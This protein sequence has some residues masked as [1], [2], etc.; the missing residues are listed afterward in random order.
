MRLLVTGGSG[1]LGRWV[2]EELRGD[3]EVV[4]AGLE[5]TPPPDAVR[6]GVRYEQADLTDVEAV[7]R[8]A[9]GAE[10]IVHLAAIPSPIG[11]EPED[12]FANNMTSTFNVVE[13]AIRQDAQKVIYSSSGSAPRLR[14][15]LPRDGPGLHAHGRGAPAAPQD[16]YGLS[17][18][19]GEE[20]L[21][22]A[23]RRTG[24]RTIVL[25]P[26]SVIGPEDYAERVPRMLDNGGGIL[27]YVDA[28]DF[29][30]A[31]RAA[32]DDT[33][34]EHDRFF[35]TA[36]DAMSREPLA[37]AFPRRF[38]GSEAACAASRGPR[39][40]SAARRRSACSA[41]ARGT[42]GAPSWRRRARD[43]HAYAR[44]P[45]RRHRHHRGPRGRAP[46]R[47]GE[48]IDRGTSCLRGAASDALRDAP[49]RRSGARRRRGDRRPPTLET[50][51]RLPTRW[52]AGMLFPYPGRVSGDAFEFRG[53]RIDLPEDPQAGNAMHGAVRWRAWRRHRLRRGPRA[54]R[55][56]DNAPR[57]PR[58]RHPRQRVAVGLRLHAAH[59]AARRPAAHRGAHRERERRA[60]AVRPRLPPLP[61]DPARPAGS[62]EDCEV[63]LAATERWISTSTPPAEVS[64]V[65]TDEW[66]RRALPLSALPPNANTAA[67]PA[68]NH[69][70]ILRGQSG[71][72]AGEEPG[73]LRGRLTDRA[74]GLE[75]TLDASEGMRTVVF[76]TPPD[77][78][79]V[80]FEPHTC[81]PN[82]F[83]LM[84]EGIPD[85]GLIVLEPGEAW[86]GWYE[87]RLDA[88]P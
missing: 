28:R 51:S 58:G 2:V 42:A 85:P 37:T 40:R 56:G 77:A 10:A 19:L 23:T 76:Y 31:V 5:D 46:A 30:R 59:R 45:L 55:L 68:R 35:I 82:A 81:M 79:V 34:I 66:P 20:I 11:R 3:H 75:A 25:R 73:P 86:D 84:T 44:R 53:R 13:A 6:P 9:E 48:R 33:E 54:G 62:A 65:A 71:D 83:N 74:N 41:T 87:L 15:P 24:I 4:V 18:W 69:K 78:P 52:G 21:E 88:L 61:V 38:P 29:A 8:V 64:P 70:F 7:A 57:E 63:A 72:E 67:G 43:Q 36:D 32:L 60:D 39:A 16:A 27:S 14:L 49:R 1:R 50:L 17:K 26:T 47:T 22:A 80:S 12:V